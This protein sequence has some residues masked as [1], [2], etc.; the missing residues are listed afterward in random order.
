MQQRMQGIVA[1]CRYGDTREIFPQGLAAL[2]TRHVHRQGR[3]A[4]L[5]PVFLS[6]RKALFQAQGLCRRHQRQTGKK[7]Y[8]QAAFHFLRAFLNS[9]Q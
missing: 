9:C 8:E 4:G 7:H 3:A 1:K 5:I 6:H 2:G